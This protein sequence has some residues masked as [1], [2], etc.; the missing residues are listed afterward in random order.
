MLLERRS[1]ERLGATVTFALMVAILFHF[2][3]DIQ[4][5]EEERFFPGAIWIAMFFAG[6][7]GMTRTAHL[8]DV[9]GRGRALF[10][11]PVD[12]SALFVGNF[13]T[14]VMLLGL[15][16]IIAVPL[17]VAAFRISGVASP[18]LLLGGLALGTWGF[19]ALGTLLSG[20]SG[21]DRSLGLLLPLILFPLLVPVALGAVEM[22]SA[23]VTGDVSPLTWTWMRMLLIFNVLFTA[24][25]ALF[26]EYIVEV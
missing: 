22:M 10:L 18:G 16:Q 8:D 1:W 4:G 20:A 19:A 13:F 25:P 7:V 9:D 12:R 5:G 14:N 23:G 24:L 21:G 2:A 11:A 17:F 3:F 6:T 15:T 26:Y